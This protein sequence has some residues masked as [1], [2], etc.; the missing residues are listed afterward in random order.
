MYVIK[1]A[2]HANYLDTGGT[3]KNLRAPVELE[4]Q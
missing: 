4:F 3:I 2:R 1:E